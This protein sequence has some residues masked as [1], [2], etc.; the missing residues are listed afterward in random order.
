M[1]EITYFPKQ[2]TIPIYNTNRTIKVVPDFKFSALAD[3][4][5]V[6][7]KY[8][9]D[10]FVGSDPITTE[11]GSISLKYGGGLT[12]TDGSLGLSPNILNSGFN[13]SDGS[14][15]IDDYGNLDVYGHGELRLKSDNNIEIKPTMDSYKT[16]I[17][18]GSTDNKA[19]GIVLDDGGETITMGT[20]SDY[21]TIDKTKPYI[22]IT[23]TAVNI[24][25]LN[26][27]T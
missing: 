15:I 25:G 12:T 20:L 7:K 9:D 8:V 5:A 17:A 2:D 24:K 22:E 21:Q 10:K 19:L 14:Y 23:K 18:S 6:N 3:N 26:Q 4:D 11:G 1:W 13:S 16:I 27:I